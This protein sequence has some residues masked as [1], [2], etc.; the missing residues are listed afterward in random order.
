MTIGDV[1]CDIVKATETDITCTVGQSLPGVHS[2]IVAVTG[3]G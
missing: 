2:I 3:K 1:S